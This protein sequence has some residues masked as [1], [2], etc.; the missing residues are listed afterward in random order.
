MTTSEIDA[1]LTD[2]ISSKTS[3]SFWCPVRDRVDLATSSVSPRML[4]SP[5]CDRLAVF[6]VGILMYD[7]V[8]V[9]LLS[10]I[11]GR[12]SRRKK[13][14]EDMSDKKAVEPWRQ[15]S[16]ETRAMSKVKS[17]R[18]KLNAHWHDVFWFIHYIYH[19]IQM[20][21][22]SFIITIPINHFQQSGQF[23]KLVGDYRIYLQRL[24]D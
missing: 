11:L 3:L 16:T 7:L 15:D 14:R 20:V 24:N 10:L 19:F 22:T 23:G 12:V 1:S 8:K 18:P 5:F 21:P 4:T 9:V 13:D 2:G 6:E 17:T